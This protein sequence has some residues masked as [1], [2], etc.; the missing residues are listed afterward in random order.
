MKIRLL[1]RK[2]KAGLLSLLIKTKAFTSKEIDVA[3]ELIDIV[4]KDKNQKDYKIRCAVNDQDKLLGYICYGPS[5]MTE[6][7]VDLYWIAV[8]PE[9]QGQGVGSLLIDFVEK[10]V[11]GLQGRMLLAETASISEY[12][13]TLRF[14]VQRGFKEVARVPD[15]YYPGNDRI[16]FC[17]RIV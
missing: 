14:Y 17:K 2:D 13:R 8:D 4:L 10:E 6:G 11:R 5:P 3:M 15:Y 16:T 1:T 9:F 7:T 12:E